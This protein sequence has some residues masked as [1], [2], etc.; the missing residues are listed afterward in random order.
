[1]IGVVRDR[2]VPKLTAATANATEI[3][4]NDAEALQLLT[5]MTF[6]MGFILVIPYSLKKL[7]TP[8]QIKL[9]GSDILRVLSF[10]A[11]NLTYPYCNLIHIL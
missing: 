11:S 2:M 9:I 7:C 8:S 1:M 6:V 3:A 4:E 5:A 10:L